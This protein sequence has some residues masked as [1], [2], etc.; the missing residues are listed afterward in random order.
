MHAKILI[1]VIKSPRF[2]PIPN[3]F[4]TFRCGCTYLYFQ[5]SKNKNQMNQL[6]TIKTNKLFYA[7]KP[8]R[9]Y[10]FRCVK[11]H[12]FTLTKFSI[13]LHVFGWQVANENGGDGRSGWLVLS[14][15]STA[16]NTKTSKRSMRLNTSWISKWQ[17]NAFFRLFESNV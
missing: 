3:Y 5:K 1:F 17:M 15:Q 9:R 13:Q 2:H 14:T 12:C 8:F 10:G 6:L 7:M 16:A 11:S 4:Y